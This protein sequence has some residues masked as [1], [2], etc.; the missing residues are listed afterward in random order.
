VNVAIAP[1]EFLP[2]LR[3]RATS[4]G[5]SRD[6]PGMLERVL[7]TLVEQLN[8]WTA[9]ADGEVLAALE[10]RDALRGRAIAW[11]EGR[12]VGTAAGID[13]EGRLLVDTAAGRVALDAGEVH[14]SLA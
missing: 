7:V 10:A 12:S 6:E 2:E 5:L 1:D 3:G 9:A 8:V 11:A 13:R 4:L 14:L